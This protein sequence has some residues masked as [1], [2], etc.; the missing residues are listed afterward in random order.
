[1]DLAGKRTR[2]EVRHLWPQGSSSPI[3]GGMLGEQGG[4]LGVRCLLWV[5]GGRGLTSAYT[6][7]T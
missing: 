2:G 7:L 6:F 3:S 1:M 4:D 5:G